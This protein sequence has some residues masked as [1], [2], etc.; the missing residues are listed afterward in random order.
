MPKKPCILICDDE[1][2]VLE[3]F[4]EVLKDQDY[5]VLFVTNGPRALEIIKSKKVDLLLLDIIMPKMSG[6]EV[7]KQVAKIKPQLK[8]II[9]T[10]LLH[11]GVAI[12]LYNKYGVV[13]FIIKPF[14]AKKILDTIARALQKNVNPSNK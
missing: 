8:I 2:G 9:V 14:S 13:D 7:V 10:A 5:D 6:V 12:E 1:I 3:G 4:K 11:H